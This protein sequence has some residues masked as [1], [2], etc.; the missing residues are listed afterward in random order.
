MSGFTEEEVDSICRLIV[1][2]ERAVEAAMR[3]LPAIDPE[4]DRALEAYIASRR[5]QP[6]FDD[7]TTGWEPIPVTPLE[8]DK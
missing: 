2:S 7:F 1:D 6:D 5:G 4:A 8:S 3:V